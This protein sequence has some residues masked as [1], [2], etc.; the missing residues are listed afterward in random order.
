MPG[1]GDQVD[2][3]REPAGRQ[4]GR[5]GEVRRRERDRRDRHPGLHA[6][7]RRRG[8]R[9]ARRGPAST[10]IQGAASNT[11]TGAGTL[12]AAGAAAVVCNTG[13]TVAAGS[14]RARS[15]TAVRRAVGGR[16]L[17]AVRRAAS[18]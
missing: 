16:R 4:L 14:Y 11:L 6:D 1:T 15:M 17:T 18:A 3:E 7:D 12:G 9:L 8:D 2:P 10:S 5:D 13:N